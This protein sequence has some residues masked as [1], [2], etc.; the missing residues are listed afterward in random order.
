VQPG[1]AHLHVEI[2]LGSDPISGSVT[3]AGGQ[4]S[5][6]MGWIELAAEIE[7]ARSSADRA[8]AGEVIRALDNRQ[9]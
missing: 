3:A 9:L 2:V 7:A 1:T 6:F 4:P 8:R 5:Q